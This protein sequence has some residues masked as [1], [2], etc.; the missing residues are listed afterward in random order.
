MGNLSI[1]TEMKAVGSAKSV[2]ARALS[3]VKN[4]VKVPTSLEPEMT[5]K[6]ARL[7]AEQG[8]SS[9]LF[10]IPLVKALSILSI[11]E[12]S[13]L[14]QFEASISADV[15]KYTKALP[16]GQK[17]LI[18]AVQKAGE[19]KL[20]VWIDAYSNLHNDET[21]MLKYQKC[22]MEEFVDSLK[23]KVEDSKA[24]TKEEKVAA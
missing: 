10:D 24:K 9:K 5:H 11:D 17:K 23:K 8:F 4:A 13:V 21:T 20:D 19:K 18:E 12:D 1:I 16:S 6:I 14:T 22:T 15:M 7:A 2:I 3:F